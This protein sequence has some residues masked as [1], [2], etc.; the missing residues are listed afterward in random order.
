MYQEYSYYQNVWPS[1]CGQTKSILTMTFYLEKMFLTLTNH[2]IKC[3]HPIQH[4]YGL[5]FAYKINVLGLEIFNWIRWP[6]PLTLKITKSSFL[7]ISNLLHLKW[8]PYLTQC[9]R[10]MKTFCHLPKDVHFNNKIFLTFS[11]KPLQ[12]WNFLKTFWLAPSI[13]LHNCLR[14]V[15]KKKSADKRIWCVGVKLH[16]HFL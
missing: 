11:W 3:D 12:W 10:Q 16:A 7:A 13:N 8:S 2:S 9:V 1:R 14:L 4:V 15:K 6:W 5:Y